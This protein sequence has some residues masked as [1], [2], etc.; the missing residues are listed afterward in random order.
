[1]ADYLFIHLN[2][3]AAFEKVLP[4]KVF[5][6]A[7]FNRFILAGVGGY[8]AKFIHEE[9]SHSFVFKPCDADELVSFLKN[10]KITERI[11]RVEF[12]NKFRREKINKDF[13]TEIL[14]YL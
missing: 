7:T 6:L 12:V 2:D 14:K 10:H 5:E 9:V 13:A 11:E 8:A 3:F 4:S 1:M